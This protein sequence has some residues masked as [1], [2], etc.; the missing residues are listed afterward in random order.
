MGYVT[1]PR[2]V[3]GKASCCS[4]LGIKPFGLVHRGFQAR[5]IHDYSTPLNL[6]V[7]M[8]LFAD[9][10]STEEILGMVGF[11]AFSVFM[12]VLGAPILETLVFQ[13]GINRFLNRM[14]FFKGELLKE[15]WGK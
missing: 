5:P 4:T 13:H 9:S 15:I 11:P 8:Q 1:K 14:P 10:S 3:W 6:L 7:L 2:E 12:V